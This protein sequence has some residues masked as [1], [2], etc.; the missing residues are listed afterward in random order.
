MASSCFLCSAND[1]VESATR[2]PIDNHNRFIV[3]FAPPTGGGSNP[4]GT[5]GCQLFRRVRGVRRSAEG[6]LPDHTLSTTDH[7]SEGDDNAHIRQ[8]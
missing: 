7:R 1:V 3:I 2:H 8:E 5:S 4:S 6:P